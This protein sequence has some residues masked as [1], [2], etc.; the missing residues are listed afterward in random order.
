VQP[1]VEYLDIA[2][3]RDVC[4]FERYRRS[5]VGDAVELVEVADDRSA[6]AGAL[7]VGN[8]MRFASSGLLLGTK[9]RE[10]ENR[11]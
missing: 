2:G 7:V 1:D 6:I 3:E 5:A 9:K 11:V 10:D 4:A 8:H